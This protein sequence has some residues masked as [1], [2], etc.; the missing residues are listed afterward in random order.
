MTI[1]EF[2]ITDFRCIVAGADIPGNGGGG[3]FS[4]AVD[5]A[6]EQAKRGW[7][8]PD[9]SPSNVPD[10]VAPD[11]NCYCSE[12]TGLGFSN[13]TDDLETYFN[14]KK[15]R[16]TGH[17]VIVVTVGTAPEL[18]SA[19]GVIASFARLLHGIGYAGAL[20]YPESRRHG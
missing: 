3:N 5:V 1:Y 15:G 13:A 9:S 8:G 18:Y 11:S 12:S 10:I 17:A 7:H 14:S 20:P 16:S 6:E 4:D 19:A 2:G